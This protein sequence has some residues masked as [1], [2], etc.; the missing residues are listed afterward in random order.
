MNKKLTLSLDEDIIEK[1]KVYASQ[2]GKSLSSLVEDFFENLTEKP[3]SSEI[4]SKIKHISGKIEIPADFD[5]E[6]E[7]RKGLEEKYLR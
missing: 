7:L 4:S 2:T 3:A 6:E 1:A 5:L